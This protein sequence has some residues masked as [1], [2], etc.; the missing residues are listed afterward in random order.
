MWNLEELIEKIIA[1]KAKN[2]VKAE[3][4]LREPVFLAHILKRTVD[5]CKDLEI[6]EI[7]KLIVTDTIK[8]GYNEDYNSS[9]IG[10]VKGVVPTEVKSLSLENVNII[11][12]IKFKIINPNC[13]KTEEYIKSKV[14]S[15]IH[16]DIEIE[17]VYNVKKIK[18]SYYYSSRMVSDQLDSSLADKGYERVEKSYSIWIF[19][20]GIPEDKTNTIL[21]FRSTPTIER[22]QGIE[23]CTTLEEESIEEASYSN[24]VFVRRENC[25]L[26]VNK[27]EDIVDYDNDLFEY[28]DCI[29]NGK[30]GLKKFIDEEELFY[31]DKEDCMGRLKMTFEEAVVYDIIQNAYVDAIKKG[32]IQGVEEGRIEGRI[33]GQKEGRI[34]GRI[35]GQKEGRIE[36]REEGRIIGM[37]KAKEQIAIEMLGKECYLAEEIAEITKLSLDKV[38]ELK[39]KIKK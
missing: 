29:F 21:R 28:L 25:P 1:S 18:R 15:Y 22:Y 6:K 34:E 20:S 4:I 7:I 9:N 37:E 11:F 5:E 23:E 31:E 38:M 8:V 14:L 3:F 12:D 26:W 24:I 36:G 30:S 13:F 35:E 10:T 39:E 19:N 27:K 16:I 2:H 33:E 17:Q 32:H